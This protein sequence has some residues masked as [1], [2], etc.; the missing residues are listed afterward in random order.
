MDYLSHRAL[1]HRDCT[2]TRLSPRDGSVQVTSVLA[3]DGLVKKSSLQSVKHPLSLFD[4]FFFRDFS[5]ATQLSTGT[6]SQLRPVVQQPSLDRVEQSV[7]AAFSTF[8]ALDSMSN[9]NPI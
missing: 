5:I 9:S 3:P 4:G 6:I 2:F 1:M 7:D 8:D